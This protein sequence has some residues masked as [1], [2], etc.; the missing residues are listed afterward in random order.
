[1]ENEKHQKLRIPQVFFNHVPYG[2]QNFH[3]VVKRIVHSELICF[4]AKAKNVNCFTEKHGIESKV[5]QNAWRI[6]RKFLWEYGPFFCFCN[7]CVTS[8][9]RK[10]G[11]FSRFL[12]RSLMHF[13]SNQKSKSQLIAGVRCNVLK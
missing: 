10:F 13:G 8:C 11:I 4:K 1:M 12:T 9:G 3:L 7:F 5:F 2:V 6:F